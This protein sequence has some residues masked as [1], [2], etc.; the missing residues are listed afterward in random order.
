MNEI[1]MSLMV[2]K[3]IRGGIFHA[4]YQHEILLIKNTWMIMIKIK[5]DLYG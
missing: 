3:D 4:I 5:N 2:E 1:D